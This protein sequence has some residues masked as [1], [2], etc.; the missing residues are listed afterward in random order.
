VLGYLVASPAKASG[1]L[2]PEGVGEQVGS[3]GGKVGIPCRS[4]PSWSPPSQG[5]PFHVP[6]PCGRPAHL[7]SLVQGEEGAG[8]GVV[9][10]VSFG[11]L[12]VCKDT[13]S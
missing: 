5:L 9:A 1:T 10:G 11:V 6:P 8:G 3:E 4:P 7:T 12:G 2:G 13:E